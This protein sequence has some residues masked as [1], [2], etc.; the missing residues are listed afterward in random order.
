MSRAKTVGLFALFSL[1]LML[2]LQAGHRQE[3]KPA[4]P[5]QS[6]LVKNILRIL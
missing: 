6:R 2:A 3:N 5:T 1:L 4:C